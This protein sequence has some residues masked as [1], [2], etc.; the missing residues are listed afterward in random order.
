LVLFSSTLLSLFGIAFMSFEKIELKELFE[1][2]A[3][4]GSN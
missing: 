1:K 4:N 3:E 2:G